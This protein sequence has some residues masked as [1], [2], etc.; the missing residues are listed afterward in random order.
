MAN[1]RYI[2]ADVS[3][4]NRIRSV[5]GV[6]GCQFF[7]VQLQT[8]FLGILS[9]AFDSD[10]RCCL[11][12]AAAALVPGGYALFCWLHLV[13]I[14]RGGFLVST[15]SEVE[16]LGRMSEF[17]SAAGVFCGIIAYWIIPNPNRKTDPA[18]TPSGSD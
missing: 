5:S 10:S 16:Y 7:L 18:T 2:S 11:G 9:I 6:L 4:S 1:D 17:G 12:S 15:I 14:L 13:F 8:Y 3:G